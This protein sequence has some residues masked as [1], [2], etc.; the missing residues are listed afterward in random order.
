MQFQPDYIISW[1]FSNKDLPV[2]SVSR[3]RSDEK[4]TNLIIDV[5]DM[6]YDTTGV[7]SVRQL[8]EKFEQKEREKKIVETTED[9]TADWFSVKEI[10]GENK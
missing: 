7:C 8:V 2:V 3:L 4:A 5:L 9:L 1:D 6:S 10:G